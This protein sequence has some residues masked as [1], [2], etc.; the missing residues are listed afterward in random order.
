MISK[1]KAFCGRPVVVP[2][3][4]VSFLSPNRVTACPT[5][6]NNYS[7]SPTHH[8][9]FILS[10]WADKDLIY[11]ELLETS[12]LHWWYEQIFCSPGLQT[13]SDQPNTNILI[14]PEKM[15]QTRLESQLKSLIYLWYQIVFAFS[16]KQCSPDDTFL[17]LWSLSASTWYNKRS[18]MN[19]SLSTNQ[20]EADW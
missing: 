17:E 1:Q 18:F 4:D 14:E 7:L 11:F 5:L 6:K 15:C 12:S 10:S 3:C 20:I 13:I 8:L 9:P 16:L 2:R 19:E